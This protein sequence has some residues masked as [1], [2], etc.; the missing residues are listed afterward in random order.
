MIQV[1]T[2]SQIIT[3]MPLASAEFSL[4]QDNKPH[5]FHVLRNMIYSN[6]IM[7]VIREYSTN[8]YDANIE[9]NADRPFVVTMPTITSLVF[10]VRDFGKGLSEAGIIGIFASY[11]ASTKRFS[12][13]YVGFLGF[14]SKSAFCYSETFSVVSYHGGKKTTYH[15]YI[16]E[17]N[18]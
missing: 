15:A 14:G 3:S 6:K 17:S 1:D 8:A 7:A 2:N 9:N 4:D 5:V 16:D 11:G 13:N 10:K 18:I 12:N